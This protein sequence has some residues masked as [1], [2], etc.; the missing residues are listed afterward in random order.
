MSVLS[1][2][3]SRK[4]GMERHARRG[5]RRLPTSGTRSEYKECA[6]AAIVHRMIGGSLA[7]GVQKLGAWKLEEAH[8][9]DG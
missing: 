7:L 5:G 3:L 6:A 8:R 4:D 1:T 9:A 2:P